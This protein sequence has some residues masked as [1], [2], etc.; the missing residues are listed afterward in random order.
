MCN[1]VS[2]NE[3]I[4]IVNPWIKLTLVS[5]VAKN[6]FLVG[7]DAHPEDQMEKW[8]EETFR[9]NGRKWDKIFKNEE[10]FLS[11]PPKVESLATMTVI[12][13]WLTFFTLV[14]VDIDLISRKI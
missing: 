7:G 10:M 11:C 9:K 6:T 13:F 1:I 4:D 14:L 5:G 8:N 12:C 2:P 3:A